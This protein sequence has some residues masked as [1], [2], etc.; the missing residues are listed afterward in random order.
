MKIIALIVKRLREVL[1][2]RKTC[3]SIIFRKVGRKLLKV[4][5]ERVNEAFKY[6]ESKSITETNNLIVAASVLVAEQL[7]LKKV[8]HRKKY[9][10]FWKRRIEGDIR[11]LRQEV[12]IM[13][14]EL[15]EGLGGGKKRKLL[16]LQEKYRVKKKGLKT[17]IEELKQ[18]MLAKSAKVRR[19][20]QRIEQFRQNRLFSVDQKR[21]YS[22]F[23]GGRGRLSDD[24]NAEESKR[25][26]GNIWS[27]EKEHNQE[28]E[29]LKDLKTGLENENQYQERV[30]ISVEKVRDQ[31]RKMPNWKAPGKDGVQGYWLKKLTNL[32]SRTA[33]QMNSILMGENSLPAW[34]THGRTVLC[35]KDPKKGNAA[36]NYRPITCLPLMWKLP[37][38]MIAE[39]TYNYLDHR[40][41]LPDE[42]KGCRR[43]SR[44]TKDHL[45]IDK[46]VLKDCRERHTNLSMVWIDYK[47]AYDLVPHSWIIE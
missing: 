39:E 41:L 46:T 9:E 10:P 25:F 11:R 44:G 28:V 18:R 7:G 19:F 20:E 12:N 47:K 21:I 29:W 2:E 13:E 36:E 4:Q 3:Q 1:V 5:V 16:G 45:L 6:L 33:G 43:G 27:I 15:K 26:W 17:V 38:G 22:E 40:K 42:Q 8:E 37:T 32:H 34:M 23:N 35:Q 30:I 14:R 24:P 31:C